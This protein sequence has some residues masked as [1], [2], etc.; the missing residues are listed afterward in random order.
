MR[1][2]D[3]AIIGFYLIALLAIGFAFARRQKATAKYFVAGRSL[4]WWAMGLSLLATIITS[5]TFIA[6]PG[7]AYAGNWSLLVPNLVFVGV[8][9]L[10][11]SASRQSTPADT[12]RLAG[13][14]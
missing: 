4:P 6:Y 12:T 13:H 14:T 8:L 10:A 7:A 11:F 3:V 9:S 2:L 5:V 1:K